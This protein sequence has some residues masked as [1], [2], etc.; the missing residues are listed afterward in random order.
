MGKFGGGPIFSSRWA[1]LAYLLKH[2]KCK[3][4]FNLTLSCAAFLSNHKTS[5]EVA[6]FKIAPS[7]CFH[8]LFIEDIDCIRR[9]PDMTKRR[10]KADKEASIKEPDTTVSGPKDRPQPNSD[11][12]PRPRKKKSSKEKAFK[13]KW[14]MQEPSNETGELVCLLFM[15][16]IAGFWAFDV[17]SR[18]RSFWSNQEEPQSAT[19]NPGNQEE[20][21]SAESYPG[22]MRF[23][24][25][26]PGVYAMSQTIEQ[27]G[28]YVWDRDVLTTLACVTRTVMV[29]PP[30]CQQ[31]TRVP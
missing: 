9:Q 28:T 4:K 29:C 26:Q 22:P 5:F 12:G 20:S 16:L 13:K 8:T 23:M 19:A 31:T 11:E 25:E 18:F 27:P 10:V 21:Q 2:Q 30:R 3:V 6:D 1:S 14:W 15:L 7:I 24:V 17:P